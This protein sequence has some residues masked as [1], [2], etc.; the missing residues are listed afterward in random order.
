MLKG[1][2][3][4]QGPTRAYPPLIM[5]GVAT[6]LL[7]TALPSA[8]TIPDSEPTETLEYAPVPPDDADAYGTGSLSALGVGSSVSLGR[9]TSSVVHDEPS[10]GHPQR[11]SGKSPGTKRCV[12]SPPRQ[13]EDLLSPPCV[14][15]FSGDNG[16]ATYQGV[17]AVE[18]R[19]L[20]YIDRCTGIG[21]RGLDTENDAG[22]YFDLAEPPPPGG[23]E[24]YWVEFGRVYQRYFNDRF[25]T[26]GRFVH[27]WIY[28]SYPGASDEQRRSEAADNFAQIRPFAVIVSDP[29]DR[30]ATPYIEAMARKGVLNFG[31][32]DQRP[33]ALF[34]KFRGR[35]W[36]FEPSIEQQVRQFSSYVC[37]QVVPFRTSFADPSLNGRPRK[38]GLIYTTDVRVHYKAL[39]AKLAREQIARCGGEFVEEA[40][41]PVCCVIR[42]SSV[43]QDRLAAMERFR[44]AGVTTVIW[45]QGLDNEFSQAAGQLGYYPEWIV[46]GDREIEDIVTAKY[47]D[48]RVWAKAVVVTNV[49]LVGTRREEQCYQ[50]L[51]EAEPGFPFANSS[52]PCLT[53]S[54]LRQL[55]IGI[56]VAGPRLTPAS[57][58]RGFHAIPPLPS[59]DPSIPACFYDLGDFTCVKDSVPLY[60]DSDA[61]SPYSGRPGCYRAPRAGGRTVQDE[62]THEEAFSYR[63]L[64]DPCNGYTTGDFLD[65]SPGPE[66]P[67]VQ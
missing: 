42:P 13:T 19:V 50:A 48:P 3:A 64:E 25:Q 60:W 54:N 8:L 44:S 33:A 16:G 26:Y 11:A 41:F 29:I 51:Q 30:R 28:C 61:E 39:F 2:P 66:S 23:D 5:S 24:D 4:R 36:G 9:S 49:P 57:V 10:V 67:P 47:N 55:F 22:V 32:F 53:Y 21:T 14:A 27:F 45:G 35:I 31:S 1:R 38:L 15:H 6:L 43:S 46:A 37:R 62:W 34:E 63:S 12:G 40:T 65:A 59:P 58:D 18:V 20:L 7:L 52:L 17:T 56:Q